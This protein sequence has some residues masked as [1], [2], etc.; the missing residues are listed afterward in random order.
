[1]AFKCPKH[2][3]NTSKMRSGSK[4]LGNEVQYQTRLKRDLNAFKKGCSN[5]QIVRQFLFTFSTSVKLHSH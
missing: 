4:L 1:M 5:D 2:S 3:L